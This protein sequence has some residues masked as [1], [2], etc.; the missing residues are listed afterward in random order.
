MIEE[1]IHH[2][3]KVVP[4]RNF[5]GSLAEP[6]PSLVFRVTERGERVHHIPSTSWVLDSVGHG[7][8]HVLH[9]T[10]SVR[11]RFSIG[12]LIGNAGLSVTPPRA[13]AE[14]YLVFAR[15]EGHR[16]SPGEQWGVYLT[17]SPDRMAQ[18]VVQL[19]AVVDHFN[20]TLN[21]N[22]VLV[23][24]AEAFQA[25]VA[26]LTEAH[27][28]QLEALLTAFQ[29][30]AKEA[31]ECA[32]FDPDDNSDDLPVM[33]SNEA[34]NYGAGIAWTDA[35][36]AVQELLDGRV[37]QTQ[38]DATPT[39]A[40]ERQPIAHLTGDTSRQGVTVVDPV[41]GTRQGRV[42]AA[43]AQMVS[44]V[45][46]TSVTPQT[47]ATIS[48]AGANTP[49]VAATVSTSGQVV[50]SVANAGNVTFHLVSSAFVGT[51]IFEASVDA[52]LNYGQIYCVREDGTGAETS[53]AINVAAAF[54]RQYTAGTPGMAWLRVRASLVTSGSIA[55]VIAPGP[56]LVETTPSLGAGNA[57][58]GVLRGSDQTISTT[59]AV[60]TALTATLPAG[61]PGLF[62]YI[63]GITLQRY[64]GA[65]LT[66]AVAP[67]V[68]TSTN[69]PGAL[70]WSFD[71]A[72]AIGTSQIQAFTYANALRSSVANTPTTIAAPAVTN[73]LWRFNITYYT[74]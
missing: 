56:T 63:T 20:H 58:I 50:A 59:A 47:S 27:E 54:I 30:C 71:T 34:E 64:A 28:A 19:Q 32:H 10:H 8:Y 43:G 72:A 37:T 74:A 13:C 16:L 1:D 7:A 26:A 49:G 39:A 65:A 67:V 44:L 68:V 52:G 5:F 36:K 45:E 62:H 61:G 53:S 33:D 17:N 25:D 15:E 22:P 31:Y 14:E 11:G 24:A 38:P 70:A 18:A 69:L 29:T 9:V 23:G 21:P 35:A 57:I 40:T 46:S 48:A 66:G 6:M 12:H 55:V 41:I 60:T 73:G 3:V 42:S 4:L 51:L 2:I